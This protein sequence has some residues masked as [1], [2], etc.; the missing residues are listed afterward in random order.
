MNLLVMCRFSTGDQLSGASGRS[1]VNTRARLSD[2]WRGRAIPVNSRIV[3]YSVIVPRVRIVHWKAP[4]AEPLVEACRAC[5]FEVEYDDVKF[6]ELAKMIRKKPPDA[7]V[8]D[9]T[10]VPSHGR[11][12]AVAF[13]QTK[14]A[15]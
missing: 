12:T 13:R 15:R 14:Y 11:D 9:L 5:G 4:E 10:C 1:S 6:G 7:L 8:I 2:T 3:D